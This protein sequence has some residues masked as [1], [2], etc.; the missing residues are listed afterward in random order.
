MGGSNSRRPPTVDAL[1]PVRSIQRIFVTAVQTV[2][3]IN[4][5]AVN[6]IDQAQ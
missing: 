3:W 5:L 2:E 4:L 1:Q 6:R